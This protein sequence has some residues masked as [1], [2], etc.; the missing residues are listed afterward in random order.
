MSR[1]FNG[2][3]W[4]VR[5][6]KG[7]REQAEEHGASFFR[8]PKCGTLQISA[9]RKDGVEV[10][11]DDLREFAKARLAAGHKLEKI[12]YEA[13][14]GFQ[15]THSERNLCWDEWWLR[16]GSMMIYATYITPIDKTTE[17]EKAEVIAILKSLAV[18]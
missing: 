4:S 7:W 16:H 14:S 8:T 17:T 6:P 5:L 12:R 10:S 13:F 2:D 3:W 15:C 18:R 11:D 1:I 9:A